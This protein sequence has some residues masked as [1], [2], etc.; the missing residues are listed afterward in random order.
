MKARALLLLGA[1]AATAAADPVEGRWDV[2]VERRGWRPETC[3]ALLVLS[4]SGKTWSGTIT[5][6]VLM[7]GNTLRLEDVRVRG[8]EISFRI[9]G[10]DYAVEAKAGRQGLDGT[11]TS[12]QGQRFPLKAVRVVV[13]KVDLF[14]KG[15][16]FP[17][18]L[19]KG[20]AGKLGL[21]EDALHLLVA[22]AAELDTDALLV[23]KDG[24]VVCERTFGREPGPIPTMSVT[25]GVTGIVAAAMLEDGLLP[26]LDAPVST[27]LPEWKEGARGAVTVRHLLTHTS[28]IAHDANAHALNAQDDRV[29][30][31][32]GRDVR[33]PGTEWSYNNDAVALLSGVLAK[34]AGKPVDAY[35][36]ERLFAPLGI[37]DARWNRDKAGNTVTY[38]ELWL[39]ARD[40]ARVGRLVADGGKARGKQV[41]KPDT[42]ALLGSDATP[43]AAYQGLLWFRI[44]DAQ[45]TVVGLRHDGW[46][47]QHLV[48]YPGKG[49][50]GVR[51]RRGADRARE[52]ADFGEFPG[53]VGALVP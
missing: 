29:A 6:R 45:G 44:L 35:A 38:A 50:V 47:G 8:R 23:L 12:G 15:L 11:C 27:W 42:V 52:G 13:P 43:V 37:G 5:F 33:A 26:S 24:R 19:P 3:H 49:L 30:W 28:G 46:L 32:L 51:L 34:A 40:L 14:E 25:K 21:D 39:T 17:A 9:P 16:A 18:D 36:A 7:N 48:I 31:V 4:R 22:R 41:L 1:L 2:T 53:L 20:D 10:L